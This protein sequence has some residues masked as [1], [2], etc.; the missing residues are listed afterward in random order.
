MSQ[1]A[2]TCSSAVRARRGA[3]ENRDAA[4]PGVRRIAGSTACGARPSCTEGLFDDLAFDVVDQVTGGDRVA[5]RWVLT[6]SNRGHPIRL[7]GITINRL[8]DG[9]IVED[10]RAVDGLELVR[11][12]GVWRTLPL[13]P[14]AGIGV[15]AA[16]E[17]T[18]ALM[19]KRAR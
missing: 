14:G 3:A 13:A 8:R 17:Q 5:G 18:R 7:W 9:R 1:R 12:L 6:G 19:A 4:A 2:Q 16:S 10:W 15:Q 11:A